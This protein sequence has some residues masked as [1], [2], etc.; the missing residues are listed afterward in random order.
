M[1]G[2][3]CISRLQRVLIVMRC[4]ALLHCC[5]ALHCTALHCDAFL[6]GSTYACI[7]HVY[8]AV[9]AHDDHQPTIAITPTPRSLLNAA[10]ENIVHH[11]LH[12][13]AQR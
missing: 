1:E 3:G 7:R 9:A 4:V 6:R 13:S 10:A 8:L 12:G 5:T 2:W 11:L